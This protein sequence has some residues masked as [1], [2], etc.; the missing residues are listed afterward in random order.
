MDRGTIHAG[1]RGKELWLPRDLRRGPWGW[2]LHGGRRTSRRTSRTRS[3][4]AVKGFQGRWSSSQE[5]V[6]SRVLLVNNSCF[7]CTAALTQPKGKQI[8][9]QPVPGCAASRGL[10]WPEV[11]KDPFVSPL[12]VGRPP[13]PP[14][15]L[16]LTFRSSASSPWGPVRILSKISGPQQLPQALPHPGRCT[17]WSERPARPRWGLSAPSETLP[18][19]ALGTQGEPSPLPAPRQPGTLTSANG[20]RC[21]TKNSAATR[22]QKDR[23]PCRLGVS[24]LR[25]AM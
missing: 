12:S 20:S 4:G 19:T 3:L 13:N 7:L 24:I 18:L 23:R 17:A 10:A 9:Q 5:F 16:R 14:P 8:A 15:V 25:E 2:V 11:H 21:G 1:P 6:S 22:T